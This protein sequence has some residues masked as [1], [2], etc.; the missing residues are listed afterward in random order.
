MN[1]ISHL[2]DMSKSFPD[3]FAEFTE[4]LAVK[5]ITITPLPGVGLWGFQA[6]N[7]VKKVEIYWDNRADFLEAKRPVEGGHG[8]E[9]DSIHPITNMTRDQVLGFVQ[10]FLITKLSTV[11]QKG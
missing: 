1:R 3:Q 5:G 7:G 8:W 10:D 2:Q 6:E 4:R 9:V 11:R